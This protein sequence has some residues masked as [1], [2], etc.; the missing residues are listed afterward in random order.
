M[1]LLDLKLGIR[2]C[3]KNKTATILNITGLIIALTICYTG[4]YNISYHYSFDKFHPDFKNIYKVGVRLYG[5]VDGFSITTPKSNIIPEIRDRWPEIKDASRFF[6]INE[7]EVQIGNQL[8]FRKEPITF[9]DDNYFTFFGFKQ[10]SGNKQI[11]LHG[12]NEVV[13][14][15]D[16]A[17][18][19]FNKNNCVGEVISI[20]KD[21]ILYRF[22]ITGVINVPD[23]STFKP[24]IITSFETYQSIY[25]ITDL[26]KLDESRN[27]ESYIKLHEQANI[28]QVVAKL[29]QKYIEKD[30]KD[31]IIATPLKKLHLE[32]SSIKKQITIL[33]S[34]SLLILFITLFNFAILYNSQYLGRLKEI[35]IKSIAGAGKRRIV[36]QLLTESFI[37][38]FAS[39]IIAFYLSIMLLE[40]FNALT[41]GNINYKN[42]PLIYTVTAPFLLSIITTFFATGFIMIYVLR[43]KPVQFIKKEVSTGNS[44]KIINAV[45]ITLEVAIF[46]AL[47]ISSFIIYQQLTFL[48]KASWGINSDELISIELPPNGNRNS[49]AFLNEIKRLPGVKSACGSGSSIPSNGISIYGYIYQD[50]NGKSVLDM[51]EYIYVDYDYCKTIGCKLISGRF[52]DQNADAPDMNKIIVN[53]EFLKYK[54]LS[55]PYDTAF[56]FGGKMYQ[57]IGVIK[58]YHVT[59]FQQKI[60]PLILHL[61]PE[62]IS[63][64]ILKTQ[65][66]KMKDLLSDIEK[67][68]RTIYSG[69]NMNVCF[70]K[71]EIE[72]AYTQEKQ[73]GS[74]IRLFTFIAIFLSCMGLFGLT[75]QIM[76]KR[77]KEIG[78]RKTNGARVT[79]IMLMLNRNFIIWIIVAFVIACPLAWFF[80]NKWLQGFAYRIELSWFVFV[81]AGIVAIVIALITVSWQSFKAA[82]KNP[83]ESLRYE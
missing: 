48:S 37:V 41:N 4:V 77:T 69:S 72:K 70:V 46:T 14:S 50:K 51:I 5:M 38:V 44:G 22:K 67:N 30:N 59:S 8:N 76:Q 58:D 35:G 25:N 80:M 24:V 56:D 61:R 11:L 71:E 42:L 26:A 18:R 32:D 65:T 64:V 62:Q 53:T 17:L 66:T 21:S 29:N 68:Y 47:L 83:L 43:Y 15:E 78:I 57:I 16:F 23:N 7:L 45:F 20:R 81:L 54:K 34:I 75:M 28:N 55:N 33:S 79:E 39:S 27:F 40:K 49:D 82:N 2:Q 12:P 13:V 73:F 63:Y 19:Y 60:E 3:L 74:I 9:A 1:I 31:I 10:I 6:D 52:F 36:L